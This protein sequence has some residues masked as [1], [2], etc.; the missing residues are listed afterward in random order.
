MYGTTVEEGDVFR[1]DDSPITERKIVD[2]SEDGEYCQWV[3]T[4]EE[5]CSPYPNRCKVS[6][7]RGKF[8]KVEY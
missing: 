4:D 6:T 7:L 5:Y 1:H 8:K 3:Y 2:V